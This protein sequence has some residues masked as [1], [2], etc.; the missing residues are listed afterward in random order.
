MSKTK[1]SPLLVL[2]LLWIIYTAMIVTT[3]EQWPASVATHFDLRGQPNGWMDR[4]PNIVAYGVLGVALPMFV[5]GIF[6]LA[7]I[8]PSRFVNIP[9]R[10]YWLAPERR[11]ATMR[12]LRRQSLWLGS[13]ILLFLMGLYAITLEANQH[14][15][16]RLSSNWVLLHLAGFFLGLAIWVVLL[17]R[18]FWKAE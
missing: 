7:S 17:L 15:P 18:R 12:E 4:I 1:F 2:I 6:C 9:R 5:Y 10:E 8:F 16:P 13:L 3:Y 11:D 14:L